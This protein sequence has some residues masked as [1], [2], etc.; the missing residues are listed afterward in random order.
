MGQN[1]DLL[2]YRRCQA[3]RVHGLELHGVRVD[4]YLPVNTIFAP[5]LFC[6]KILSS[7]I[8]LL[9]KAKFE[10]A[11]SG[12]IMKKAN[13]WVNLEYIWHVFNV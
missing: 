4:M 8:L 1:I 7:K 5:A 3:G 10:I 9:P 12:L 13:K 6:R 11:L 2:S